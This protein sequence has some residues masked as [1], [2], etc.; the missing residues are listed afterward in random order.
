[1]TP[2]IAHV[3][4]VGAALA[5]DPEGAAVAA[6]LARA[7][8]LVASRVLVEDDEAAL[9]R[10]LGPDGALTVIL[11]GAGSSA[12]DVVRR[13][14]SRAV[15]ARLVLNQRMLDALAERFRRIDRPLPRRADR[16]ALLPQGATVWIPGEGEPA[17]ALESGARRFVVLPRD[18]FGAALE[19][20]LVPLAREY[21]TGRGAVVTRVLRTAGVGAGELEERLAEW[22]GQPERGVEVTVLPAEAEVWVRLRARGA[23]PEEALR[24][25]APTETAVAA[26]LGADCYGRDAETLELVVGR[27]LLARG[28]T[29]AVAESCTGGLLGHRLTNVPG[30]SAYFERGVL[31]YSNRAKQEL[32]GVPDEVLRAHGAVSAAC[33]EAMA[34]GIVERA[35]AA[36]GLAI[37]GIAGPD[38]GTPAKPVGT[39]FVGLALDGAVTSRHLRLAGDR[40]RVKWQSTQVALD[41]LRRAL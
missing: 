22:I 26:A 16:L 6:V 2:A 13:V 5:A 11:A 20:H 30:S 33:A 7:G 38:G 37:T 29:L 3:V 34:R 1:M 25:L 12:G 14:L 24:A 23:S 36:C 9:Q 4:T 41:M 39:V 35:G 17:W 8:I 31:V 21:A 32:L 15:G 40:A 28:L 10:A 19:E 18:G 27:R